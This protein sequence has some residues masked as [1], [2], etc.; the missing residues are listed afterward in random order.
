MIFNFLEYYYILI[1]NM[2]NITDY[3]KYLG[4]YITFDT[5]IGDKTL[6]TIY[7][8]IYKIARYIKIINSINNFNNFKYICSPSDIDKYYFLLDFVDGYPYMGEMNIF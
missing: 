4:K 7:K 2:S 6:I 5:K 3:D 8:G 1:Y